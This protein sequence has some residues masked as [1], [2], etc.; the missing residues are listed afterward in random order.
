MSELIDAIKHFQAEFSV[1]NSVIKDVSDG[2]LVSD[3]ISREDLKDLKYMSPSRMKKLCQTG[4]HFEW[5]YLKN[6]KDTDTAAKKLGRLLHSA[7]LEPD[8]FLNNYIIE[9]KFSGV[10]MKKRKAD[11]W[12]NLNTE[13]IVM[14]Q[15]EAEKII[16]MIESLNSDKYA[17]KLLRN[18]VPE[19]K[20]FAKDT[21]YKD[22]LGNPIQWYCVL[23]AYRSGNVVIEVKTTRNGK[24]RKFEY[25]CIELGYHI[26]TW[27]NR[28]IVQLITGKTPKV[29][30]IDVENVPPYCV[31]VNECP[32]KWFEE[33][34]EYI[35]RGLET[36]KEG[37]KKGVW[38]G[39]QKEPGI[40]LL[41]EWASLPPQRM[42]ND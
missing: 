31:A 35:F 16:N 6:Q 13:A 36:F 11:W 1:E 15:K 22:H 27:I 38:H 23:D 2:F 34:E 9:P 4:K 21:G 29:M 32:Y 26:Q 10:G 14:D 39:W 33:T 20:A 8:K 28:R 12:E 37:M 42:E 30:V 25:D 41:P 40:L 3:E 19:V 17:S 18:S 24:R 5:Y 7:L